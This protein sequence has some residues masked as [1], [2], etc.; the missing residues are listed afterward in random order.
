MD[1]AIVVK[2]TRYA[3]M[4]AA[5]LDDKGRN[6]DLLE[7]CLERLSMVGCRAR[8]DG[9][10]WSMRLLSYAE[11]PEGQIHIALNPRFAEALSGHHVHVSLMERRE[12]HSDTAQLAHAWLS[13]WLRQ[14]NSNSI[15]LDRLAEK[16]W[17]PPSK[18][19]ATNRK[20]RERIGKALDEI[21]KLH[22]WNVKIEGRGVAAKATI[23]RPLLLE[24]S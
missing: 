3:L 23:K 14:G 10:D 20:R 16:V 22:G 4:Q 5:G 21:S 13:A 8:K 11:T 2:T 18:A 1:K 24:Q 17:G 12:L 7:D 6:Y 19:A 15:R 9:Y